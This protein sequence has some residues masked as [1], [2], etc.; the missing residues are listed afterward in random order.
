MRAAKQTLSSR[1]S[2]RCAKGSILHTFCVT[3]SITPRIPDPQFLPSFRRTYSWS[4]FWTG[5]SCDKSACKLERGATVTNLPNH[6]KPLRISSYSLAIWHSL[7]VLFTKPHLSQLGSQP[8]F[9]TICT[10]WEAR[11]KQEAFSL[12]AAETGLLHGPD[13]GRAVLARLPYAHLVV[14]EYMAI[15]FF[16][17]VRDRKKVMDFPLPFLLLFLIKLSTLRFFN[18]LLQ[19]QL[20]AWI[21][22]PHFTL[23]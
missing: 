4:G 19:L 22:S 3:C 18:F 16:N 11:G 6:R 8:Q 1:Y 17:L 15:V 23:S 5:I 7:R 14:C 10:S 21:L 2:A 12:T 13:V 9:H 20:M